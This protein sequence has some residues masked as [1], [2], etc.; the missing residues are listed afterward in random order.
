[1]HPIISV[2]H[3]EPAPAPESDP[4]HWQQPEPG[5]IQMEGMEKYLVEKILRK[6]SRSTAGRKTRQVYYEVKWLGY[7][8]TSWVPRSQLMS[9]IPQMVEIFEKEHLQRR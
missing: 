4:Y 2:E 7:E 3:L 6:E 1:V 9:D 5:P 8:E